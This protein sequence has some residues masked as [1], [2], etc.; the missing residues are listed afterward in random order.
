MVYALGRLCTRWD[1]TIVPF[2]L[3]LLAF[4]SCLPAIPRPQDGAYAVL[5]LALSLHVLQLHLPR[6]PSPLVLLPFVT[7]FPLATL[8]QHGIL[9]IFLPVIAFFL[10]ALLLAL[11]LLSLSLS[12]FLQGLH[13]IVRSASVPSPIEA[14]TGFLALLAAVFIL[15]LCSLM[16]FVLVYPH[17]SS[18]DAPPSRWDRYSRPIG[19]E[20]RRAM[21]SIIAKY[22]FSDSTSFP[23][24]LNLVSFTFV[25]VPSWTLSLLGFEDW[26]SRMRTVDDILWLI[27]AAPLAFDAGTMS[28]KNKTS[29]KK[30]APAAKKRRTNSAAFGQRTEDDDLPAVRSQYNIPSASAWSTRKVSTSQVLPL[31]A[32]CIQSVARNFRRIAA[33]DD[34][35][36]AIKAWFQNLP[37]ALIPKL[38]AALRTT[39]PEVLSNRQ[40]TY[41]VRGRSVTLTDS[42]P[43][44]DT[45][46][47]KMLSQGPNK[48]TLR[49]VHLIGLSKISDDTLAGVMSW[50]SALE[51]L[52]LRG[53]TKAGP[54]TA[55][56]VGK[57]CH[58]L[59]TLNLNY[60]SV[61]PVSLASVLE[62]CTA[63][64]I[65]KLAG[66]P[67]WL[68]AE[69]D[70][71]SHPNT[72]LPNLKTLK[73]RQTAVTDTTIN[74]FLLI[75]PNIRRLDL[76]FT[77]VRQPP[78]LQTN[79]S[80][81]KLALTSTRMS[82][83]SLLSI[84]RNMT[85]LRS[86]ALGGFG[87]GR[88]LSASIS[89]TSAMTLTDDALQGITD[90]LAK[91]DILENVSLVGNTK[92]G[93]MG[94]Q[95]RA[96][97]D[98][99]QRV[100][101]HCTSLNLAGISSLRSMDL[102][103][104]VPDVSEEEPRLKTLILNNTNIDDDAAPFI[105][106]C[107][108]LQ[109]LELAGTKITS[110]GIFP[111]VDA[112]TSLAQLNLTSCRG[113]SVVDRRRFFEVWENEWKDK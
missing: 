42:L 99:I 61:T 103:G 48:R 64:E 51:V 12:D 88:G 86:L 89:N 98:F 18:E 81:E 94:R 108:D 11:F 47:V 93:T 16:M 7:I 109:I 65:I 35:W 100:G 75:C 56:A 30:A 82:M 85:G 38:F 19:L 53:C 59:V 29:Q 68:W 107:A 49:E 70:L 95:S 112:C 44:V 57:G 40:I 106:S 73:L 105:S 91:C 52:N 20:A 66:I 83:E 71:T 55:V 84:L 13:L 50:L 17:F 104:L 22:S 45:Q 69:L 63:L 32:L 113:V 26:Q 3:T 92:L 31:T 34:D 74:Q 62:K 79:H 97:A 76:S 9:K 39:C 67:N 5:L 78:A 24:P 80:L 110:A 90:T 102:A 21:I 111:I 43:G 15:V 77:D 41:F 72:R 6:P 8:V 36:L 28:S 96:L 27:F 58:N 1:A 46:T 33:R 87:A 2:L 14:R 4:L 101:R 54:K 60:T 10:P 25:A 37:E 23:V